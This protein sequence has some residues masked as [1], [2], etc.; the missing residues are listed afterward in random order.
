MVGG[1]NHVSGTWCTLIRDFFVFSIENLYL[2]TYV[3][4]TYQQPWLYIRVIE[5]SVKHNQIV[6]VSIDIK[7]YYS[8]S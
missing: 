1:T 8:Y 2:S 5:W 3:P 4:G 6:Y 7:I